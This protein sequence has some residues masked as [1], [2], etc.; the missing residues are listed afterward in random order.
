MDIKKHG[1]VIIKFNDLNQKLKPHGLYIH[2]WGRIA[3]GK[4]SELDYVVNNL[5]SIEEAEQWV[6]GF[7]YG[8]S[9][10]AL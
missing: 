1:E 10:N 5:D 8:V 7:L 9:L 6:N 4:N 3:I 2:A